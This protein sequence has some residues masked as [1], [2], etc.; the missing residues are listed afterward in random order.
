MDTERLQEKTEVEWV[1]Q[2]GSH[3]AAGDTLDEALAAS[4]S[5]SVALVSC[6]LCSIY[7][8]DGVELFLWVGK[9]LDRKHP[10]GKNHTALLAGHRA[11]IA[12][13]TNNREQSEARIF[14]Q[15]SVD[16]GETFVSVPLLAREE[17]V[18]AINVQHR[19]PRR[20]NLRE[21][22]LLS[23]VGRLLGAGIAISRLE[24]L[25][26]NLA[27]ELETRKL[28]ER[29]KGILQRDHGLSE[30]QAYLTLQRYSRQ[31]RKSMKEIAQA[32]VLGDEVKRSA[33]NDTALALRRS[34]PG[35]AAI[36]EPPGTSWRA[37]ATEG[38]K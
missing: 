10:I 24:N 32:I 30:E 6:D 35:N 14:N 15:W 20:Y 22:K 34:S 8:R 27:L 33:I 23:A 4:V 11:P 38:C 37:V 18:G 21:V 2:I 26:S 28:V 36:L 12:I 1:H 7:V 19:Q 16:P 5:F 13:S 31:K 29:G 3:I 17:I 25:N 9:H